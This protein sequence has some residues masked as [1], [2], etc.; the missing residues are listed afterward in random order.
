MSFMAG[1]YMKIVVT[2]HTPKIQAELSFSSV[3]SKF[4]SPLKVYEKLIYL[5]LLDGSSVIAT[6]NTFSNCF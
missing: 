3:T 2:T 4:N 5:V 6:C 1:K